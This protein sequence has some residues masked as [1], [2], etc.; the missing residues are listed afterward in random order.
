MPA[1]RYRRAPD[2]PRR[3]RPQ[4]SW[5]RPELLQLQVLLDG[6]ATH[7]AAGQQLRRSVGSVRRAVQYYRF[8]RREREEVL[9]LAAGMLRRGRTWEDT[10]A[11]HAP[12]YGQHSVTKSRNPAK[13]LREAL[14]ARLSSE[15]GRGRRWTREQLEP[16]YAEWRG[17]DKDWRSGRTLRELAAPLGVTGEALNQAFQRFGFKMPGRGHHARRVERD[18]PAFHKLCRQING[19]RVAD[20]M[21]W[22][23]I[24]EKRDVLDRKGAPSAVRAKGMWNRWRRYAAEDLAEDG[25]E[26]FIKPLGRKVVLIQLRDVPLPTV[27]RASRCS[28]PPSTRGLCRTCYRL[29]TRQKRLAIVALPPIPHGERR[30]K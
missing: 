4:R 21:S 22:Q 12:A 14:E 18:D 5:N 6:G 28:S 16:L 25:E 15:R 17:P 23:A 27:C 7:R 20:E 19:D 10:L 8:S 2:A 30:K 9:R 1:V 29:A 24:A 3:S 26:L 11:R 13:A